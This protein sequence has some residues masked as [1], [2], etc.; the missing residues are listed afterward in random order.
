MGTMD[1]APTTLVLLRHGKANA[2]GPSDHAR[3]LAVSGRRDAAA[4]GEWLA[5]RGL[6]PD[7]AL[8]SDALRTQETWSACAAAGRFV[9]PVD[10]SAALYAAEVEGA[11]GL[12]R[13]TPADVGTLVVVGHNPTI[14]LLAQLLDD[15]EGDPEAAD[16]MA[17]GFPTA[18]LAVLTVTG[19]W[20]G[21]DLGSAR[22]RGFHV[23]RSEG[24]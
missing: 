20:T 11:L 7:R 4:A 21:L 9:C 18:A 3:D 6:I 10:H 13:S 2:S 8:V 17:I 19:A 22:L 23:A 14:A 16:G 12:I 24:H 15:G 5:R 1:H